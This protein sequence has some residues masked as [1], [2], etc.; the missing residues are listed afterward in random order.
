MING[1]NIIM[2]RTVLE[3]RKSSEKLDDFS[4]SQRMR[5]KT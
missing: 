5:H 3:I 1:D 4:T 2:V